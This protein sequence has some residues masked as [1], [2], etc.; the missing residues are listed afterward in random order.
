MVTSA[1]SNNSSDRNAAK[2][3]S[4]VNMFYKPNQKVNSKS[5]VLQNTVNVKEST[6]GTFFMVVG[7]QPGGYSGIQ[8]LRNNKRVAIFSMWCRVEPNEDC[9]KEV[10][11]G[12][13]VTVSRFGN[14]GT[15]LKSMRDLPWKEN[16]DVTFRVKGRLVR[17]DTWDDGIQNYPN[18]I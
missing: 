9:P 15:G 17:R 12:R 8:Q 7:W 6:G 1:D 3:A 14:E 18:Q 11:N 4:S 5:W 2:P 13:S 10:S 16:E